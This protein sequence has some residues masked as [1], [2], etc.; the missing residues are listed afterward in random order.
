MP[1]FD[2]DAFNHD[3][4]YEGEES[5]SNQNTGTTNTENTFLETTDTTDTPIPESIDAVVLE[6]IAETETPTETNNDDSIG[7]SSA[8]VVEKW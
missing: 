2:F 5:A 1:D 3:T 7:D 8:E 6:E 4:P